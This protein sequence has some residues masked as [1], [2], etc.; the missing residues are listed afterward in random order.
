[1]LSSVIEVTDEC[2]QRL[3]VI[4]EEEGGADLVVRIAAAP[5]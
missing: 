2:A 4:R 1:M 3:A 5:G